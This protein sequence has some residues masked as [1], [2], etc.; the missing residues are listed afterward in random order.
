MLTDQDLAAIREIRDICDAIAAWKGLRRE[1]QAAV[2]DAFLAAKG[3]CLISRPEKRD[4]SQDD[5][6]DGR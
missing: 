1:R 5:R 6:T 2:Y 4:I 3:P